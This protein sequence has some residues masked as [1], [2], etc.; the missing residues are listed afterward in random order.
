[1]SDIRIFF[2]T[3]NDYR[4]I[5]VSGVYGGINP[6][7]M[8][9]ADLFVEKT[10]PPESMVIHV[11]ETTGEAREASRE[12]VQQG[13]VRELLVG[14]VMRP[15]VAKA[16]GLWLIHQVEQMEKQMAPANWKQ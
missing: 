11:D 9:H 7:G 15:E 8:V 12:P 1:M 5:P 4:A 14:L 13:I 16:I 10:E 6:Q 3:G 2:K